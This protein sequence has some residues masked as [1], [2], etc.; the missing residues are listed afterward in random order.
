ML[1]QYTAP[2]PASVYH[3][4]TIAAWLGIINCNINGVKQL[5]YW[6][7]SHLFEDCY[8]IVEQV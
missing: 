7:L 5:R 6:Y 3:L 2:F 4:P 1:I 8:A